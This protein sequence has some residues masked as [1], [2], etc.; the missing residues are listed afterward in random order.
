PRPRTRRSVRRGDVSLRAGGAAR[1]GVRG[2]AADSRR[3]NPT[4]SL[5]ELG[6]AKVPEGLGSQ[7]QLLGLLLVHGS[8]LRSKDCRT[9]SKPAHDTP[10]SSRRSSTTTPKFVPG[11]RLKRRMQAPPTATED[12]GVSRLEEAAPARSPGSRSWRKE[13]QSGAVG[14]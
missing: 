2:G 5:L 4:H 12:P 1:A 10:L 14:L 9:F 3:R 11:S 7:G 8:L 6:F 13:R